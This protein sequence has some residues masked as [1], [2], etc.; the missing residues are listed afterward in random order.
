MPFLIELNI[1][2]TKA[3]NIVKDFYNENYRTSLGEIKELN[4]RREIPCSCIGRFN[5]SKIATLP[6]L[7]YIFNIFLIKI[8]M[9]F[10]G[11]VKMSKLI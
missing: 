7:T 10:G 5:V 1:S 6:K 8:S 9:C 2:N 3:N 11:C 4:K